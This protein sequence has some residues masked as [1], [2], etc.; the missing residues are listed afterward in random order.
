MKLRTLFLFILLF[1]IFT[2][3]GQTTLDSLILL[4]QRARG[5]VKAELYYK[6][7]EE[8]DPSQTD[9]V[10]AFLFKAESIIGNNKH[11][12]L[13][14]S[15]YLKIGKLYKKQNKFDRSLD[16]SREAF[17]L[18]KTH[19]DFEQTGKAGLIIGNIYFNH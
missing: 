13:L 1:N 4:S 8:I 7:S 5:E 18:F 14:P 3:F 11:S 6:I 10:L 15:I 9:S 19:D 16:Y 2:L 17:D 12:R